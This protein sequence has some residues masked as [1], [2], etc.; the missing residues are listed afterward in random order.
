MKEKGMYISNDGCLF[1]TKKECLEYEKIILACEEL[2]GGH[3]ITDEELMEL[4]KGDTVFHVG[5]KWGN[6]QG[7]WDYFNEGIVQI[8]SITKVNNE[9]YISI[10]LPDGTIS[11]TSEL[12]LFVTPETSLL[13]LKRRDKDRFLATVQAKSRTYSKDS[14]T[15]RF[16]AA[17]DYIQ[18]KRAGRNKLQKSNRSADE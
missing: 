3:M 14:P 15:M 17:I 1:D 12:D 16:A 10:W 8:Q 18:E 2:I 13:N 4:K 6:W 9:W 7:T 11:D 5:G